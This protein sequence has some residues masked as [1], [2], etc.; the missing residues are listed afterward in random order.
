MAFD[1]FSSVAGPTAMKSLLSKM[2]LSRVNISRS[3]K[4][5]DFSIDDSPVLERI[6][7]SIREDQV[8]QEL[9]VESRGSLFFVTIHTVSGKAYQLVARVMPDSS[10]VNF[11]F[12]TAFIKA[13]F[14]IDD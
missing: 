3:G 2:E 8:E 14:G 5:T 6:W 13:H 9:S 4:G 12:D 10:T 1:I 11:S 7:T